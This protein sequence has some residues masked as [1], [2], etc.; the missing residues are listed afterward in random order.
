MRSSEKSTIRGI[1]TYEI[2]R[3]W[4]NMAFYLSPFIKMFQF[5]HFSDSL[6]ITQYNITNEGK[7]DF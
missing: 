3:T 5:H 7:V 4:C 6:Y 2:N 1:L